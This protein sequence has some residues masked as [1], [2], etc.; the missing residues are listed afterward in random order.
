M[1]AEALQTH[2]LGKLE[3][4]FG[5]TDWWKDG[6]VTEVKIGGIEAVD[7]IKSVVEAVAPVD[8]DTAPVIP[9]AVTDY[10]AYG[11]V[12]DLETTQHI[13]EVAK[14]DNLWNIVEDKYADSLKDLSQSEQNQVLARLFE[15]VKSN[16]EL[17]ESLNL[18]S[19]NIELIHPGEE[20]NLEKLHEELN[21]LI[22][23]EK[24]GELPS[25]PKS[26][27]LEVKLQDPEVNKIPI[28][29]IDQ[30][31]NKIDF[32]NHI[33]NQNPL[34][35][36]QEVAD[37]K[38]MAMVENNSATTETPTHTYT[39]ISEQTPQGEVQAHAPIHD[40]APPTAEVFNGGNYY[41]DAYKEYATEIFGNEKNLNLAI[42]NM[43]SSI[44]GRAYDFFDKGVWTNVYKEFAGLPVKEIEA[45]QS[46]S[47]P[48]I[49]TILEDKNIKPEAFFA[50]SDMF[51][52]L[53]QSGLPYEPET[54]LSD[55]FSRWV[56]E[57]RA[58][59]LQQ[60]NAR[61]R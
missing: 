52:Q 43:A 51:N 50:W 20:I 10:E 32:N 44:E 2:L 34:A 6:S 26:S 58:H 38:L 28:N 37:A 35:V 14:G 23:L 46:F 19:D 60:A 27:V 7:G 24:N 41:N 47:R 11:E 5:H 4:H 18:R 25:Y 15:N 8:L 53:K 30:T 9:E 39:Q 61:Y 13:Y 55:L 29:F 56:V 54:K 31:E 36:S 45:L 42:T 22:E 57:G 49:M 21:H 1:S 48:Q 59:E 17:L 40:I 12:G 33:D 16:P 3:S